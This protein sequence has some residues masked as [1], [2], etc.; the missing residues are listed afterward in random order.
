MSFNG[1]FFH[2]IKG[3]AID[4]PMSVSYR[5]IFMS[6]FKQC[7]LLDYEQRYKHKPALWLIF[8][9]DIFSV[10][11]GD[12]A[13]FKSFLK[14]CNEYIKSRDMSSIIKFS[15]S[16][17]MSTVSFLDGKVTIEKD[18]SLTTSHSSVNHQ[19]YISIFISA[20]SNDPPHTIKPHPKSQ[21]IHIQR[22]C[23]SKTEYWKYSTEFIKFCIKRGY[24]P[25]NLKKLATKVSRMDR[26]YLLLQ[27]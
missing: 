18:G 22:I 6:E 9:D 4:T 17:S 5:N 2:Q 20:K 21:F 26:N 1:Q 12:E 10:W 15:Y 24:K 11:I 3:T 23:S 25:A 14:F 13:S 27:Y 8:K 7:L 19:H 16:Y